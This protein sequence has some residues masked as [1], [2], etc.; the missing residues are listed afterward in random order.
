MGG[1][2]PRAHP[3]PLL[4]LP[5]RGALQAA[6]RTRGEA[7]GTRPGSAR[8]PPP[9]ADDARLPARGRGAPAR[10]PRAPR[11]D[12]RRA[13]RP[14]PAVLGEHPRRDGR[15]DPGGHRR[16]EARG[17]PRRRPRALP[18]EG[19]GRGPR[20]VGAH[21]RRPL[22]P[23]RHAACPR[24]RAPPGDPPRLPREGAGGAHR[25]P[26][27]HPADPRA[28]PGDGRASRLP[29]LPRLPPR[30]ADGGH[31][32]AGA[33][34]RRGARGEDADLLAAGRADARGRGGEARARE[35]R[36]VGRR[37][38]H[39]ADPEGGARDRPGGGQGPLPPRARP[40][41]PASRSP[42][43]SSDSAPNGSGSRRSGTRTSATTSSPTRG[44]PPWAGSTP[45][46][47]RG[48]RSGRARG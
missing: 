23:R 45:T 13:R 14:R 12:P 41:R 3:L 5:P 6:L 15:L 44:A 38:P 32:G 40:R 10:G 35:P 46:S 39:R 36:A 16:G 7:A 25:Q 4:A 33:G 24:P 21:P 20:G 43:A 48:P 1:G 34:L 17:D 30:G 19:G 26:P 2:A 18:E 42:S 8:G 22:R 11:G 47:S 37:L 27:A 28:P 31:R 29:R 9:R